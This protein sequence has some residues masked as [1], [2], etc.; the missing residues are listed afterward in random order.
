M[1]HREIGGLV[2]SLCFD[3]A[4]QYGLSHRDHDIRVNVSTVSPEDRTLLDL[5]A[6]TQ[7]MSVKYTSKQTAQRMWSGL[8]MNTTA[9]SPEC[10]CIIQSILYKEMSVFR[11][12]D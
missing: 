6:S 10:S 12:R 2:E 3:R 7:T 5:R 8:Q 11:L 9:N 1:S 4:A